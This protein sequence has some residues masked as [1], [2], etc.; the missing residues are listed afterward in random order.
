[1]SYARFGCDGSDV[2]VY[3][4]VSGLVCCGCLLM[5]ESSFE[6]ESI[7]EM[8]RHLKDHVFN[9]HVVPAGTF[10]R[11]EAELRILSVTDSHCLAAD[12]EEGH[13][14]AVEEH[15]LPY[16]PDR[17]V[18]REGEHEQADDGD[19]ERHDGDDDHLEV[20][21]SK[22]PPSAGGVAAPVAALKGVQLDYEEWNAARAALSY[23]RGRFQETFEATLCPCCM[24][25]SYLI[26]CI[27]VDIG[28]GVQTG[29]H[30]WECP[31]CGRFAFLNG[32]LVFEHCR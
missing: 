6:T 32:D 19:D 20:S 31:N 23:I 11:L 15:D 25:I 29:N 3:C 18:G 1:M 22:E 8:I 21:P 4:G 27:E 26:D 28:V 9:G 30:E 24:T 16:L 14:Q 12:D 17:A 13:E 5:C 10:R 7:E 2:Y